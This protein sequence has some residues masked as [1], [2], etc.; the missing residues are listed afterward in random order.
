VPTTL[1]EGPARDAATLY[2]KNA[3]VSAMLGI[4]TAGAP[5]CLTQKAPPTRANQLTP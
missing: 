4:A 2:P 3:N 5:R 1:F